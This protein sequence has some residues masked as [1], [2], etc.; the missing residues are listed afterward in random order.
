[1]QL[2]GWGKW[3]LLFTHHLLA[4]VYN[5]MFNSLL[6]PYRKVTG[7]LEQDQQDITKLL[8]TEALALR[9]EAQ[10]GAGLVWQIRKKDWKKEVPFFLYLRRQSQAYYWGAKQENE[11]QQ[12]W[13]E[14]GRKGRSQLDTG[15]VIN[16][17]ENNLGNK[18]PRE[19]LEFLA[20]EIFQ[21]PTG[22]SDKQ[23]DL[24]HGWLCSEQEV[25]LDD[26][27]SNLCNF[28]KELHSQKK[29]I[30]DANYSEKQKYFSWNDSEVL[31][32]NILLFLFKW[33]KRLQNS[34]SLEEEL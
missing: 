21:H 19:V 3:F 13:T 2:I 29:S 17:K 1:M 34:C 31:I 12:P 28:A 22:K 10:G 23:C 5:A 30:W 4:H 25:E 26:L 33:Y 9:G 32:R 15:K 14:R 16:Y 18:L 8:G 27:S 11:Q 24:I 7:Q 20:L 6:L